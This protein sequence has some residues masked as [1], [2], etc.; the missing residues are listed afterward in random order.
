MVCFIMWV[1]LDLGLLGVSYF[2]RDSRIRSTLEDTSQ[3]SNRL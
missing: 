2:Y 3:F 1:G